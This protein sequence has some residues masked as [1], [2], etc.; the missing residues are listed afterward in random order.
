VQ[1]WLKSVSWSRHSLLFIKSECSPNIT[2]PW[3][4]SA[5]N[6]VH[7][8]EWGLLLGLSSWNFACTSCSCVCAYLRHQSHALLFQQRKSRDSS[9]G[10]ATGCG[11]DGWGA[12]ARVSVGARFIYWPAVGPTVLYSVGTVVK[13]PGREAERSP[14][15]SADVKNT[16]ICTSNPPYVF[17]A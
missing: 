5:V 16:W 3:N 14:P 15:N 12:G 7:A 11:L 9:V 10:I 1:K 2:D 13:R 6:L 17:V 8:L 4:P